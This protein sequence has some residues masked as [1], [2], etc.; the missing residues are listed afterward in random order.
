MTIIGLA[1][2]LLMSSWMMRLID[3]MAGMMVVIDT[4]SI[5]LAALELEIQNGSAVNQGSNTQ[6]IDGQII[7]I[8][9]CPW[10]KR[11]SHFDLSTR[12]FCC[13]FISIELGHG[14]LRP[15]QVQI[16]IQKIRGFNSSWDDWM[17]MAADAGRVSEHLD[18]TRP[19]PNRGE[20][21][22]RICKETDNYRLEFGWFRWDLTRMI[23]WVF[24]TGR[25]GG[26]VRQKMPSLIDLIIDSQFGV[27][28]NGLN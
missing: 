19:F 5:E 2:E 20:T 1:M 3:W 10:L 4:W 22:K 15:I 13:W 14:R 24:K 18:V 28:C 16:R 7:S 25:G 6:S 27:N 9:S 21:W 17:E 26:K 8:Y 23:G 11:Q 12:F